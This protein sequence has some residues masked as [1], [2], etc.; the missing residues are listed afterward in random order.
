MHNDLVLQNYQ[1]SIDKFIN[2]FK[3]EEG[4][5]DILIRGTSNS[6]TEI[7]PGWSDIDLSLVVRN[8][9][10]ATMQNIKNGVRA[11]KE[12]SNFKV[13]VTVVTEQDYL[14]QYHHH[15]IKPMYYRSI[16]KNS[17]SVFKKDF[18]PKSPFS[19][20]TY[21]EDAYNNI[22]YLIHD[23]RSG[24]LKYDSTEQK[25]TAEFCSHLLKRSKH[26]ARNVLFIELGLVQEELNF[27]D[28]TKVFPN[29]DKQFPS[30]VKEYKFAWSTISHDLDKMNQIIN[31]V[32]DISNNMFEE[33]NVYM[34]KH[35]SRSKARA[36]E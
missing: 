23:L 21:H 28:F 31:E 22:V 32:M 27:N 12:I 26:L 35:Y 29:L 4:V 25:S 8:L 15:G 9:N 2:I 14:A 36:T 7:V 30:W 6:L 1:V 10:A 24:Y 33:I 17:D 3:R 16:L 19:I 5:V 13:S 11:V 20:K 18:L 34:N